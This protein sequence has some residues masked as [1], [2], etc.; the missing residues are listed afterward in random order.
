M[1]TVREKTAASVQPYFFVSSASA[2]RSSASARPSGQ[3]PGPNGAAMRVRATTARTS[4]LARAAPTTPS[5]SHGHRG[6][7]GRRM[8]N[9]ESAVALVPRTSSDEGSRA[10]HFT[11]HLIRR[12]MHAATHDELFDAREARGTVAALVPA[13][14]RS[15]SMARALASGRNVAF[16]RAERVLPDMSSGNKRSPR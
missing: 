2:P 11:K 12:K 7:G 14:G 9:P 5:D 16:L 1:R 6:S 3:L 13:N 15:R 8:G 10:A 4:G